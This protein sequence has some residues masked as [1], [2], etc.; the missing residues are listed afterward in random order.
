MGTPWRD[1]PSWEL[2]ARLAEVTGRDIGRLLLHAGAEEL[3]ETANAQLATFALSLVILDAV[4]A[5]PAAGEATPVAAAG[6]SLGE[7]SALVAAGVLEP[8]E[9]ARLVAARGAAMA[10]AAAARPGTMAAVLGLDPEAVA[11]ACEAV[12]DVWVANDN[13]TG[14]VVIAG[15]AEG[16]AAA[17]E[18]ARRLGARR[19]VPL[20][21]GGAF[22]T[23]LMAPAQAALDTALAAAPLAD[24]SVGCVANVDAEVH[25]SAAEWRRLLSLQ[26]TS[27]VLWRASL[28]RLHDL[29]ITAFI[30]LGPGTELSGMVKR[31]VAGAT[32]ANVASPDDLATLDL[33]TAVA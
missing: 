1:T 24:A 23:P 10:A 29:G 33:V 18:G 32:R 25:T 12:A 14:Q 3:K 28:L 4:R 26:L 15:T 7:Y 11:D 5:D 6:H 9:G 17:T 19:V 16:V 8:D 2:V 20:A 30:E 13:A 27:P 21:V 31:T 22:H